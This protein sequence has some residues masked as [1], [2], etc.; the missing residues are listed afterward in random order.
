[1]QEQALHTLNLQRGLLPPPP[2]APLPAPLAAD[3]AANLMQ[4]VLAHHAAE[5][6]AHL[7]CSKTWKGY[8]NAAREFQAFLDRWP[9]P[10]NTW[11][12][13]TPA[14]VLVYIHCQLL[15]AHRGRDGGKASQSHIDGLLSHLSRVFALRGRSQPWSHQ[16]ATGNPVNSDLVRNFKQCYAHGLQKAGKCETSAVPLTWE[17]YTAIMDAFDAKLHA[18]IQQVAVRAIATIKRDAAIVSCL[19]HH[20]RRGQDNQNTYWDGL[21]T[22]AGKPAIQHWASGSA[23]LPQL[24]MIPRRIKTEQAGRVGTLVL[25][26]ADQPAYCAIER[27]RQLY[28]HQAALGPVTGPI[29][30]ALDGKGH[31]PLSTQAVRDRFKIIL[32]DSGVDQGDTLH[33]MRRG[34][35]QHDCAAGASEAELRRLTGIRT[36]ATLQRYLDPGRHLRLPADR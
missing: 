12:T 1:V 11:D 26:A 7:R 22:A 18:A 31:R 33:D 16:T 20:S 14:E 23:A 3:A 34:C 28:L 19:W 29:F 21:F 4:S 6:A 24:F 30:V 36:E 15:P 9:A 27:L 13:C 10:Y 32:R 35:A 5:E 17:R 2:A 25:Q 8:Q